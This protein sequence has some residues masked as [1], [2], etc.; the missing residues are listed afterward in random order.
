MRSIS[1]KVISIPCETS[2][3]DEN[4]VQ[5]VL[6]Y[7]ENSAVPFYK[8][9]SRNRQLSKAK[10]ILISNDLSNRFFFDVSTNPPVLRINPVLNHDEG[11]YRCRVDYKT[12][13]TQSYSVFMEVFGKLV[14]RSYNCVTHCVTHC[15][16]VNCNPLVFRSTQ[17]S[18][19][20]E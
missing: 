5:L 14:E 16:I 1:G 17:R 3:W 2:D 18:G 12:K 15:V 8:L 7:R 13:R 9:D 20:F 10:H 19:H 4:E 6:W 11:E